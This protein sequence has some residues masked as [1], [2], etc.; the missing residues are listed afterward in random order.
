[1]DLEHLKAV[2][3]YTLAHRIQWKE[4]AVARCE[5]AMRRDP[6]EI[7]MAKEAVEEVHE[8]YMEQGH[9]IKEALAV[10]CRIA[11]NEAMAPLHGDHPLYWE[12]RKD[13][14]EEV[15]PP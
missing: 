7:Y 13:L 14:G 2:L 15:H 3:P 6:L 8:R 10:A 1:M 4:N 12:I 5:K 9:R 11:E